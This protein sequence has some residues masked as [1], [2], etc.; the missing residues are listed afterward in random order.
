MPISNPSLADDGTLH[1]TTFLKVSVISDPLVV[2]PSTTVCEA[3]ALM[4]SAHE[5]PP[6]ATGWP[7]QASLKQLARAS[8][9]VVDAQKHV[10]GSFSTI[11]LVSLASTAPSL[12]GLSM[13]EVMVRSVLHLSEGDRTGLVERLRDLRRW[14]GRNLPVADDHGALLGILNLD[15]V[16][17]ASPPPTPRPHDTT[18]GA[19]QPSSGHPDGKE[20]HRF[21]VELSSQIQGSIGIQDILQRTLQH[22][23]EFLDCSRVAIWKFEDGW[24]QAVVVAE[25]TDS[26]HCLLDQRFADCCFDENLLAHY[27][28]GHVGIMPDIHASGLSE[29]YLQKLIALHIRAKV[30]VPL[31][32][33]GSLWGLLQVSESEQARA[34]QPQEVEFLKAVAVQLGIALQQA[35]TTALLAASEERLRLALKA[36]DQGLFD[37][38]VQTGK[39]MVSPEY[40]LMVG[41]DPTTF[42]ET[43]ERW[44]ERLHPD[45]VEKARQTYSD[46]LSGKQ[47]TYKV[48]FRMRNADG[49]WQWILSQGSIVE[50]DEVGKPLRMLGTHT[51]ISQRKQAE[52]ALVCL[53]AELEE[54][55]EER[56]LQLH[57]EEARL[58]DLF[59]NTNDL[60]QS[61]RL[62]DA[63]FEFVNRAWLRL[64]GYEQADL[65]TLS[66]YD[67][68]YP[69]TASI[70]RRLIEDMRSGSLLNSNTIELTFIT[71]DRQ[72]VIVEG[73]VNCRQDE[74]VPVA[75]RGIFR[76]VTDRKRSEHL[77][78][79]REARY[80]SLME[81]ASDAILLS[82]PEGNLLEV[83]RRA[84]ELLGRSKEEL[85]QMHMS[86]LH[87]SDEVERARAA[88]EGIVEGEHHQYLDI[89]VQNSSGQIIPVDITCT[90]LRVGKNVIIQ[91]IFRDISERHR[92][93][94]M[95]QQQA[96][97]E[98]LLRE[99]TQRIRQSL[100]LQTIFD[101]ACEEIREV[102]G[103]DRVGVFRFDENTGFNDGQFVA[104]AVLAAYPSALNAPIH[105]HCF[106]ENFSSLYANGH[107]YVSSDIHQGQLQ[108]CHRDILSQFHVRA[109]L[110]IPLVPLVPATVLWGLLCIHQCGAAREWLPSEIDLA[111]QLA[112]QLAIATQQALLYEQV[113]ADLEIRQQVERRIAQQLR[114]QEALGTISTH[115]RESLHIDGMLA[116]V[117]AQVRAILQ[118]ERVIIFQ[119]HA[120]GCSQI[121]S[122]SV[123]PEFPRLID[124]SWEDEVWDKEILGHYLNGEPRI[125]PDVMND[126]WTQ[127]LVDY[128]VAG[129]I[130][131][132]IV[133]PILS[134]SRSPKDNRWLTPNRDKKLWGVL[135]AHACGSPR[136]W[137]PSE[138]QLL[139]QIANQ[140][141]L[142]INQSDLFKQ[143]QQELSDRQMAQ[144]QLTDRNNELAVSNAELLR[145]TQLKDEFLANMSH[146]LRTPLNVILG[147]VEGLQDDVFGEVN[148]SQHKAL[149]NV[150][151]SATHLLELINDI[152][153]L[154]KF[155]AG[156]LELNCSPTS[157]AELCQSSLAFIKQ[158]ASEKQIELS[159]HLEQGLPDLLIDE[160][161]MRQVLIN[162]LNNAVKFTN[163]GGMVSLE[164]SLVAFADNTVDQ[165]ILRLAVVDTGIGIAPDHHHKLFDPFVQIDSALNRQY[166][167]TGL[168][169]TL[170]KRIVELHG[171]QV[172]VVSALGE[173]ST[174]YVDLPL[175]SLAPAS[176]NV[177]NGH[178]SGNDAIGTLLGDPCPLIL[179]AEDNEAN[180][181]TISSYLTAKG[182]RLIIARSGAEALEMAATDGLALILMD[183]QMPGMDGIEAMQRIRSTPAL[184]ALP[185]IALTALAMDRDRDR[186]LEAGADRYVSKPVKLRH[187]VGMIEEL[188][189]GTA[190]GS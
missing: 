22:C 111:Q 121:V 94:Q 132:K 65:C 96:Q 184:A 61:V 11:D 110:V 173:G 46:Y 75:A 126:R 140:L 166:V 66:F 185:I 176:P 142:A 92:A 74:G 130:N 162:L 52:L 23:R 35:S 70:C 12:Q 32:S 34:W 6:Q 160:R 31:I 156:R 141:T 104:E 50:W 39:A 170:V 25:A 190:A 187:L 53:N 98:S 5:H 57:S 149:S 106:G 155:D 181:V 38:N 116:V 8:C 143:L 21:L 135:V 26:S 148:Q 127:C 159:V 30:L 84:E 48:E 137:K 47:P 165:T 3:A 43:N 15:K 59:N 44:L 115:I 28:S 119:L 188:R 82:D 131:S 78:Q 171:G 69:E 33:G 86:Q 24:R 42:E 150:Q 85:V 60:I 73:S 88:F 19:K 2:S 49:D 113:Q 37:V 152:L 29:C 76:D 20:A 183:V 186:C 114:Q 133:A 105:D 91:G 172:S 118:C 14:G 71:K 95:A 136:V 178:D 164:A 128:S 153:D 63:H 145:A 189:M 90:R 87:P 108:D 161:R 123:D 180:I 144:S 7:D 134:D 81:G 151:I 55:V 182:Y 107:I 64:L 177:S 58:Q 36:A 56:T 97:R 68:I 179:L 89:K 146:E 168:G 9:V 175:Q 41:Y 102:L 112:N 80:R 16:L 158:Q 54:R 129:L 17:L 45:D 77:L 40:A 124:M 103:A 157:V 169:L 27:L 120:N 100:D 147:M 167:G 18:A 1:L 4:A 174:F 154:S 138:A 51:E 125:V 83:N 109:N 79:E 13:A 72:E 62:S 139:Q 101:T 117:S 99:V 93:Q 67:I 163:L 10:L 122:E